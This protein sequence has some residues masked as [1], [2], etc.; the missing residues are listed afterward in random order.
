MMTNFEELK[1]IAEILWKL[2]WT[3]SINSGSISNKT[4]G[5]RF[6]GPEPSPVQTGIRSDPELSFFHYYLEGEASYYYT[7]EYFTFPLDKIIMAY[8]TLYED[9]FDRESL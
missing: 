2:Q 6:S 5:P 8:T 9:Q 7:I 1:K 3:I 4:A